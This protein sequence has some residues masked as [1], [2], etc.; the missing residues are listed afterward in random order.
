MEQTERAMALEQMVKTKGWEILKEYLEKKSIPDVLE[1]KNMDAL[2]KQAYLNGICHGC[3]DTLKYVLSTIDKYK[4]KNPNNI[5][6][7]DNLLNNSE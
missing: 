1:I 6:N 5:I 4:R 3:Q 7:I 2:I